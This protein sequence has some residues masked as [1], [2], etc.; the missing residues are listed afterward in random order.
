VAGEVLDV[1]EAAAGVER[2]GDGGVSQRVGGDGL[3][4]A[5]W[6]VLRLAR[7]YDAG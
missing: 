7:N 3:V 6:C 2:G 5:S 4:D 1:A